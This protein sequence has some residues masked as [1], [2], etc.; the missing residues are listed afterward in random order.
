M[1]INW[2]FGINLSNFPFF[3]LSSNAFVAWDLFST[4]WFI[5]H[6]RERVM[7]TPKKAAW[8]NLTILP[9]FFYKNVFFREMAMIFC[10][11]LS[12]TFPE[13]VIE[14]PQVVQKIRRFLC[15]ILTIFVKFSCF[16][17]LLQKKL[18][19]KIPVFLG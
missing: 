5:L 7:L 8:V 16:F 4:K 13:K 12:H 3:I 19:S 1:D 2:R 9:L 18:P 15:S 17:T 14:I 10:D 11:F 6:A